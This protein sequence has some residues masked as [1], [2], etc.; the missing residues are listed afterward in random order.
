MRIDDN[1]KINTDG[2]GTI[3]I[4]EENRQREKD[5]K[6][7][8]FV[9]TDQWFYLNVEQALRKYLDLR[10]EQCSDVSEILAKIEE[11]REFITNLYK[12]NGISI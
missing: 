9:F 5:G 3:L 8:D 10:I 7:V 6:M 11:T 4:F 12:K 2:A 1:Y